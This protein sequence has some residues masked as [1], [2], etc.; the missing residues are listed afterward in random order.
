MQMKRT[1]HHLI[2]FLVDIID[3]KFIDTVLGYQGRIVNDNVNPK[4]FFFGSAINER[5]RSKRTS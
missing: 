5:K 1:M 2:Y 4:R 3:L